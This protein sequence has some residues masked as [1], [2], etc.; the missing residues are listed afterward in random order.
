VTEYYS[1]EDIEQWN[2]VGD[3]DFSLE[4][5]MF[6]GNCI[7]VTVNGSVC[8]A[9]YQPDRFTC[10]HDITV[11]YLKHHELNP[12]IGIFLCTVI[13]RDKYRWSYGRKPHD[14]KKFG[15]SIIKLPADANGDPDWQWMEE[16]IKNL[17]YSDRI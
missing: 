5:K 7:A 8:N 1:I 6:N 13:M 10:S 16:Y 15:K 17:P 2:K 9:F 4:K 14:V 12:Y 3:E 11:L